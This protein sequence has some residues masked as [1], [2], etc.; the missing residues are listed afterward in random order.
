M[1][2]HPSQK[3]LHLTGFTL[4]EMTVVI[5]LLGAF[6]AMGL[7]FSFDSY[8]GY[9][10]RSEYTT[11]FHLLAKARN[12]ALNNFNQ[13]SHGIAIRDGEYRLFEVESYDEANEATY[14][15][16]PR[17]SAL[18]FTGPDEIVFEQLSG[19]LFSCDADPCAITFSY[20]SQ[21]KVITINNVGGIMW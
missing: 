1:Q 3:Y 9:L 19:N 13:S 4:I 15:S 16:Y 2:T 10:F 21:T 6:T 5:G 12:H 11:V 20:K 8:R 14:K 7:S 17:N 18:S